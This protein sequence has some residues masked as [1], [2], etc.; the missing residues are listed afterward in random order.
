MGCQLLNFPGFRLLLLPHLLHSPNP[1]SISQ[2]LSTLN[3]VADSILWTFPAGLFT[4]VGVL[5][6]N[7]AYSL[8]DSHHRTF[9]TGAYHGTVI[10]TWNSLALLAR[11]IEIH[12]TAMRN[13]E[14]EEEEVEE[15]E[16]EEEEEEEEKEG[17][18]RPL[19]AK[20][21]NINRYENIRAKLERA[22]G[23]LW[24]CIQANEEHLSTE[25]W[26]WRWDG[27]AKGGGKG[28]FAYVPLSQVP[29]SDGAG[30][31]ESNAIQLWSLTFLSLERK[32]ELET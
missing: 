32:R 8:D 3:S 10:W 24:D 2:H 11:G 25:V 23:K 1:E 14:E 29:T 20:S 7:P 30:Q 13:A 27:D 19:P 9:T 16:V 6:A 31:T 4:R 26:S 21:L 5:I 28:D 12:L 15:E 17:S 22:Y 18:G